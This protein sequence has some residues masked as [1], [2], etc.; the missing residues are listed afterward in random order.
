MQS[1]PLA[2]T[3]PAR[4]AWRN[5]IVRHAEVPPRELLANPANWRVHPKH[6]REALAGSLDTVG[7]VAQVMVNERSGFVVDGHAR[8]ALAIAREE[9][10]V[11]VAFVDLDRDE[12]A[13][14]L[15]TLDPIGALATRDE[16]QL[17]ALLEGIATEDAG[18]RALLEDLAG[19]PPPNGPR[20]LGRPG[21]HPRRPV[22][23]VAYLAG[24]G[25][26]PPA[27]RQ[28]SAEGPTGRGG[29]AGG[30]GKPGADAR[31]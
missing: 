15:A 24:A 20:S 8:V 10:S 14:V 26:V 3:D 2:P 22:R 5:R 29:P 6:Q 30:I 4:G 23:R 18:L 9:P 17:R 11:P 28:G 25:G 21:G 7:W 19:S 1:V 27:S 16:T 13:L 12:E 31:I